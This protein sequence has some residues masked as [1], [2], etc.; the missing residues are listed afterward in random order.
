[1]CDVLNAIEHLFGQ[2]GL[3]K[4]VAHVKLANKARE[5]ND[6]IDKLEALFPEAK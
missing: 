5:S 6:E 3:D 1:L 2:E 4:V